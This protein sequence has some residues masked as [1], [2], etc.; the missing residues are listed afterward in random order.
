MLGW[1]KRKETRIDLVFTL[2]KH[3]AR[4]L[5][6]TFFGPHDSD[7][8]RNSSAFQRVLSVFLTTSHIHRR[9]IPLSEE[10][11]SVKVSELGSIYINGG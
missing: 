3:C 2:A 1:G 6:I 11:Q 4:A 5:H 9:E 10:V 7:R 8:Q